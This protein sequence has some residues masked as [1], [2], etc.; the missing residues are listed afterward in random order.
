MRSAQPDWQSYFSGPH[1]SPG[2]SLWRDFMRWQRGLNSALRP[3]GL[4]QPQFATLA[5]CGWMT[6]DGQEIT[7]QCVADFVGLDRM[8]VSQVAKR[9]EQ[10][11]LIERH[12]ARSDQRAK[13]ITLTQKGQELLTRAI[14]MV[15]QFDRAYFEQ[16]PRT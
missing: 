10:D 13:K 8:H 16:V 14:P 15:E 9:L 4:T 12:A 2:F 3:L 1:Q 5:V 11:G 7:Q 6:R